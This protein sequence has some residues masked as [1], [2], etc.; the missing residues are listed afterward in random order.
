LA[1]L[2]AIDSP[3]A[4]NTLTVEDLTAVRRQLAEGQSLVRETVD[5]LRQ[6]QEESE[7][8]MRRRDELEGR[9]ASLEAEYEELLEKTINDEETSNVDVAESMT[10]LKVRPTFWLFSRY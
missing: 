1:K 9:L 5:R 8:V 3:S 6:S 4:V 7:M 10:D 2:D